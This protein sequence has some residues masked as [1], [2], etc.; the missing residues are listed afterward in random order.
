MY[1]GSRQRPAVLDKNL[2]IERIGD[3]SP[4]RPRFP[5]F[6]QICNRRSQG[7]FQLPLLHLPGEA[8]GVAIAELQLPV[9]RGAVLVKPVQIPLGPPDKLV[10]GQRGVVI[11]IPRRAFRQFGRAHIEKHVEVRE[12]RAA[13]L[14][15]D[16]HGV[17]RRPQV[18]FHI[19]AVGVRDLQSHPDVVDVL[20]LRH[21]ERINRHRPAS[22]IRD[23]DRR[24]TGIGVNN[25][26]RRLSRR[27]R[28]GGRCS[29]R[30][31]LSEQQHQTCQP[32]R[33]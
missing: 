25:D 32:E 20:V 31:L 29:Q 30:G 1:V 7:E 23:D 8:V 10:V 15:Q 14:H 27:I 33:Q 5:G 6:L 12:G 21:G 3:G 26:I 28:H 19:P 17:I 4:E 11:H 13:L 18:E 9:A 16:G 24:S 2:V 22:A